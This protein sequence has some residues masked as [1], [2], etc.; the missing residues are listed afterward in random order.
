MDKPIITKEHIFEIAKSQN[1]TIL[2]LPDKE[3]LDR[4][5]VV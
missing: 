5:S 2:K 4:K 3:T 1:L